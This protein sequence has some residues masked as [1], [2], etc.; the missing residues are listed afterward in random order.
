MAERVFVIGAGK[1]GR[2]LVRAFRSSGVEVVGL[3][4]RKNTDD[5]TS[6][7]EYPESISDANVI[8]I[9]VTDS[10]IDS[11]CNSLIKLREQKRNWLRPGTVILH[12][13]GTVEPANFA[14][15]QQLGMLVGTFHPLVPFSSA[16][17]GA[18]LVTESWVGIDGDG[19][20]CAT[21][22]RLAAALGARTVNIPPGG[23]AVYHAAAVMASNFP[24]VLA[25]IASR[26]LSQKGVPGRTAEQVV[27]SLMSSA[28]GNLQ[29][30][31]PKDVLTGPAVRGDMKM[32]EKHIAGLSG[33]PQAVAVYEV[34]TRAALQLRPVDNLS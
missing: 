20:A 15:L 33:D 22:R 10:E 21:S 28:V 2:G 11:V 1:V 16:E 7:G 18:E 32:I 19:S 5:A 24:I 34:L 6:V 4:A 13:S 27:Q 23:K 8:L 26:V 14:K 29:F 3:H 12:T 9:A 30:G 31:S 17:R 25:A